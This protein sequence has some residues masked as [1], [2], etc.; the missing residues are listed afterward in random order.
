MTIALGGILVAVIAIIMFAPD[1]R[2][3]VQGGPSLWWIP[4]ALRHHL[5]GIWTRFGP[6]MW[7]L[8]YEWVRVGVHEL[9][10]K[11]SRALCRSMDSTLDPHA[12]MF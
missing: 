7:M 2:A 5:L 10:A 11:A 12:C 9:V 6:A 3:L 4:A 1:N 8:C